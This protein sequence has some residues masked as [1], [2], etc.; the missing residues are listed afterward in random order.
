MQLNH[1]L[2][3]SSSEVSTEPRRS[4]PSTLEAP[5]GRRL[6]GACQGEEAE[7]PKREVFQIG[8]HEVR[9]WL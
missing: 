6:M 7:P 4:G 1:H 3:S 5:Q 2:H 8:L 9:N